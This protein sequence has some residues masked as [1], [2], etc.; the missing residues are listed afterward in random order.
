MLPTV[1]AFL[2]QQLG[3]TQPADEL[4]ADGGTASSADWDAAQRPSTPTDWSQPLYTEDGNAGSARHADAGSGAPPVNVTQPLTPSLPGAIAPGMPASPPPYDYTI[5]DGRTTPPTPAGQW[6]ETPVTPNPQ[7]SAPTADAGQWLAEDSVSVAPGQVAAY[8]GE[9]DYAAPSPARP[10]PPPPSPYAA[11]QAESME[12][13]P[14]RFAPRPATY[15]QA[16]SAGYGEPDYVDSAPRT[17]TEQVGR[18]IRDERG[19]RG[20]LEPM[21]GGPRI[22]GR[23]QEIRRQAAA[24]TGLNDLQAVNDPG[25]QARNPALAEEYAQLQTEFDLSMLG[26]MDAPRR[27]AGAAR[28]LLPPAQVDQAAAGA[29]DAWRAG[30]EA[31][32]EGAPVPRMLGSGVVPEPEPPIRIPRAGWA[33][34][35]LSQGAEDAVRAES[36]LNAP[37]E[38]MDMQNIAARAQEVMG[39]KP[40]EVAR[41]QQQ[42]LDAP[43]YA[44]A[45]RGQALRQAEYND[46][47]KV[48]RALDRLESAQARVREVDDVANLSDDA[49]LDV[50]DATLEAAQAMQAFQRSAA[51]STAEGRATARA[52]AQRRQSIVARQGVVQAERARQVGQDAAFAARAVQQ[53]QRTGRVTGREEQALRTL[54]DKLAE[55]EKNGLIMDEN[56]IAGRLDVIEQQRAE[57]RTPRVAPTERA[58]TPAATEGQRRLRLRS[59]GRHGMRAE[60]SRYTPGLGTRAASA[61]G[62]ALVP[63]VAGAAAGAELDEENPLR[64]AATGFVAGAGTGLVAGRML[65]GS[66]NRTLATFGFS[67]TPEHPTRSIAMGADPSRRYTFRYR[68]VDL[69]QL[70]ASHTPGGNPNPAFPQELQPRD[71]GRAGSMQQ[72]DRIARGLSPDA[73][74]Y[75]AGRL[76]SGPMIV[77]PD[78]IV[79][80][81]NGRTLALRRAADQ[82]PEQYGQYVE[83]MRANLGEYG[84]DES[85]LQGVNRPVLVRERLSDVDRAAFAAEANNAG[86]LQMSAFERAAQDAANLSDDA[87]SSIVVGEGDT[88]ASA[89]RRTENRDL[90][91]QWVG[92]LAPNEQAGVIDAAGNLSAQG[93]ERLANALLMRTYGEGAGTRLVQAFVE[94]ADPQVRNVQTAIMASLPDVARAEALVRAGQRDAGLS[95][96]EDVAAAVDMLA[97][98]RR[99]GVRV[100]DY[101]GQRAM[102]E[103]ELTPF[104]EELLT[105]FDRNARRQGAIRDTLR[106]YAVRV[107]NSADPNQMGMFGE[108]VTA[109]GKEDAWRSAAATVNRQQAENQAA[110]RARANGA[111]LAGAADPEDIIPATGGPEGRLAVQG[112]PEPPAARPGP[113]TGDVAPTG[114]PEGRLAVE[115]AP[116]PTPRPGA[117]PENVAPVGGP[118]G[119]LDVEGAPPRPANLP[120][121]G[122]MA[123]GGPDGTLTA[124]TARPIRELQTDAKTWMQ[125]ALGDTNNQ[126]LDAEFRASVQALADHSPEGRRAALELLQQHDAAMAEQ[127][128]KRQAGVERRLAEEAR[129]A[130]KQQAREIEQA[131]I[132]GVVAQIDEVL[133]NPKAPGVGDRLQNLYADLTEISQAGFTRSSE[134]RQRLHRNGLLRAGLAANSDDAAAL[135]TAL[136]RISPGDPEG[137]R[138]ILQIISKPRLIDKLLEYQYVNMLSS[139]ITQ[140]VNISSNAMQIAGRLFLQ[141]PLEFVYSGGQS[142]GVRAAFGGAAR[143]FREALP[144]AKQIMR[145]GYSDKMLER[146]ADLGDYSHVNREALTEQFGKIGAFLHVLSTR[147]LQAMD[148]LLGHTAYAA[149]AE[150]FAQRKADQLL[151]SKAPSVAGMTPQQARQHVLSNIWDYPD[152]IDK[153]GKIQEYTL[154][155]SNDSKG[156]G[157]GNNVERWLRQ[158]AALRNPKPGQGFEWQAGA[159]VLNQILPFFNVPLNFLKQGAERTVGAPANAIRAARAYGAGDAERGAELAAKAT[160]GAGAITTG[161]ALALG[162][163]LTGD[164]P[165]DPGQRAVW[166]QTHKRNSFRIPGTQT[167]YSWEGTPL[168]IPFGMVAGAKEGWTEANERAAK[169]G[170]TDTVD[171]IGSAALKGAQGA[172]SG[173]ASQS[174]IRTLGQQYQLLTGDQTGLGAVAASAAGTASRFLPGSGMV[175]WLARVGDS[176]ERDPGKPQQPSEVMGNVGERLM[177]RVPGLRQQVDSRLDIYGEPAPNE[178]GGVAGILPYYRGRG[179]RAGD[180]ITQRL[181]AAKVG[182]PQIPSEIT[183]RGMTIPFEGNDRRVFQ[184]AWGKAWRRHL[185]GMQR[186]GKDYPPEAYERARNMARD[187]AETAVLRQIGPAEIRR[188]VEARRPVGAR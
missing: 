150:Q 32:T 51:A 166:E 1:S 106:D 81:G 42:A 76:D 3:L 101:L 105:F 153:A 45:V 134:I 178:Q 158:G 46:A 119:A 91:R 66:G 139:P 15:G 41:W 157:F 181:E 125:R 114:G 84:L 25:W 21:G 126:A 127:A 29:V 110:R 23:M 115:G 151:R 8:P 173:F 34:S 47:E 86:L 148:A 147:P 59:Q 159:F 103:R 174:F 9:P 83:Q 88:I 38:R 120:P 121:V 35:S 74:L 71:R 64:G 168:A 144:E 57:A 72:V 70:T 79:E 124:G 24:E 49:R 154:L 108:E 155:R 75:D 117:L 128:F 93:Y 175:N 186:T 17:V 167:W 96:A 100:G 12:P 146:A 80:S 188:R 55:P 61:I 94:S 31:V 171:V 40:D 111:G 145:T 62:Q 65:R 184:E 44:P 53:V 60:E 43:A 69:D 77:G 92:A 137:M 183:F 141:N 170:Q 52:L 131:R 7:Q 113:L 169:K 176:V 142:G 164:G 11:G 165:S 116:Q 143:G 37:R 107:E 180:P 112:A 87:V 67:P 172:A 19:P 179:A 6:I 177:T 118:Q 85:A 90:V 99:E 39:V 187:E 129:R 22:M 58:T 73:L 132:R 82:Y 68:V 13:A 5:A 160:I 63:G 26:N 10:Q 4:P 48:A 138:A 50:A 162:D 140:A 33:A 102:F 130:T 14:D 149:A 185:E 182:A 95:V 136:S 135:V 20:L 56:G 163:N 156:T 28:R 54:R 97:R 122:D 2:K 89:L 152:I 98:L 36:I 27:V 133:A 78:L 30:R 16:Q 123:T 104:Q 18:F 161:V 109:V